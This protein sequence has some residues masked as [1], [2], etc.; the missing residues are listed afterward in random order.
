MMLLLDEI[1]DESYL[2]GNSVSFNTE[3]EYE[4]GQFGKISP[5]AQRFSNHH[6]HHLLL[7]VPPAH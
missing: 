5:R 7:I 6:E 1:E 3:G 4:E 2:G